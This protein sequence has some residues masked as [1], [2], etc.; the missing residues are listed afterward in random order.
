MST[1]FKDLP[2]RVEMFPLRI[3]SVFSAFTWRP[4][5]PAA[6]FR[7]RSRDLT[8]KGYLPESLYHQHSP[9]P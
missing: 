2:F 9:H 4:M 8:R 7:L 5:P 1:S 6:R 3:N